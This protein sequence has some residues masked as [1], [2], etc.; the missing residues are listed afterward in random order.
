MQHFVRQTAF[1]PFR[2][3]LGDVRRELMQRLYVT[4]HGTLGFYLRD[5][6]QEGSVVV[7]AC[8]H[9][10]TRVQ[11]F[12]PFFFLLGG[13]RC[14]FC[15]KFVGVVPTL[16]KVIFEHFMNMKFSNHDVAFEFR[17]PLVTLALLV[18]LPFP[19]SV[20]MSV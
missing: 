7:V 19:M 14:F 1:V 13:L 11:V 9:V 3:F 18:P 6:L 2:L 16:I 15:K 12:Y 20:F 10:P 17:D 4:L 8:L 5:A